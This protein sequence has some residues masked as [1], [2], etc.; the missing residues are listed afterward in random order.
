M[1]NRM[2][3]GACFSAAKLSCWKEK[4]QRQTIGHRRLQHGKP[5]P[6]ITCQ[7]S[8]NPYFYDQPSVSIHLTTDSGNQTIEV[9]GAFR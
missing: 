8:Q 5:P 2:P 9:R 3:A 7:I 1:N 6:M 4:I